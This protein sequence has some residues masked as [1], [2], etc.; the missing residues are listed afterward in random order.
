MPVK[1]V[2]LGT[3]S[4]KGGQGKERGIRQDGTTLRLRANNCQ[5]Q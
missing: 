5:S 1:M 3:V 4:G 2:E